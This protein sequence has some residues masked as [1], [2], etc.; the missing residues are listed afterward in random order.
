MGDRTLKTYPEAVSDIEARA[1]H[2]SRERIAEIIGID[3]GVLSKR[4]NGRQKPGQEAL[5]VVNLTRDVI[6]ASKKKR[7]EF[8]KA[9]GKDSFVAS[10]LAQSD[11]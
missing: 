7:E 4:V 5:V 1:P 2:L 3:P 6:C 8:R 9:H 11:G 10:V